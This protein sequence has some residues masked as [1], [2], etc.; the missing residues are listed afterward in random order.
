MVSAVL[1]RELRNFLPNLYPMI[2]FKFNSKRHKIFFL[3]VA[4]DEVT[5]LMI[6]STTSRHL[7]NMIDEPVRLK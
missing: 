2:S 6:I 3:Q 5:S 1:L 4:F 7:L